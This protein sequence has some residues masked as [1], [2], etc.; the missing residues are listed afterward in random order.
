MLLAP[1]PA[2]GLY[3][4]AAGEEMRERMLKDVGLLKEE[5][6]VLVVGGGNSGGERV[7][8]TTEEEDKK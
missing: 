2:F 1:L 6:K 3:Y 4:L 7:A 8:T 5:K